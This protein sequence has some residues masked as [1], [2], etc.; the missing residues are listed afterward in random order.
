[1]H[2]SNFDDSFYSVPISRVAVVMVDFQKD[3]CGPSKF[4]N[5]DDHS[6][7]AVVANKANKFAAKAIELGAKVV[8]SKQIL[9]FDKLT[10][11]QRRWEKPDGRCAKDSVGAELFI[12]P[13]EGSAVI[14]KYRYDIWQSQEFLEFLDKNN[15]DAVIICGVELSHCVLYATIGAAERGYHYITASDL[16]SGQNSGDDTYNKAVRDFMQY[17]HPRRYIDS[18]TILESWQK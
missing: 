5:G 2:M 13:V 6:Q 10:E 15:I 4:S 16:V 9:D 8:Y 12:E 7:N 14:V 11:K 3:F 17:T 1:M 18:L